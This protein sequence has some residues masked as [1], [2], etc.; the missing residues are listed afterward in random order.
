M[1]KWMPTKQVRKAG[2]FLL[3]LFMCFSMCS[4]GDNKKEKITTPEVLDDFNKSD[5]TIGVV[6]GYIFDK[7]VA[8]A[9]PD[10][11]I[12][13]FSSRDNA[14]RALVSG[15]VDGVADDEPIIRSIMRSTDELSL[16]DGYLEPAQ[17]AFVF[18][19]D[20]KGKKLSYEFSE[21]VIKL[22]ED[23]ELDDLEKKWFGN[24]T[25]DK[26]SD[27][28]DNLPAKNGTL[29]LAFDDSNIPFAYMSAGKP[30]GYDIDLAIGFCREYGYGLMINKVDF[31]SVLEKTADGVYDIGCGAITIT[32]ER[33]DNLYFGEADYEGGVCIC[34][35]NTVNDKNNDAGMISG[36]KRSFKRVFI[37]DSRYKLF[38]KGILIT[39]IITFFSAVVGAPFG[40][41]LYISSRRSGFINRGLSK[42]VI[43]ILHGIPAVM[44]MSILYYTYYEDMRRGGI[45]AAIIGFGLTFSIDIYMIIKRYA[46]KIDDGNLERDYRLYAIDSGDFFRKLF[47]VYGND[48]RYD[49]TDKLTTLLKMTSVVGYIAVYD[50]TKIFEVIKKESLE[51][52]LPLLATTVVYFIIIK[53]ISLI[54]HKNVNIDKNINE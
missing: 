33:K 39:L 22:R 13:Y 50:M 1:L 52:T 41:L 36:M 19:K 26:Q 16:I 8:D 25:D 28:Y 34:V 7:S 11:D 15:V 12:K 5:I 38:I 51:T 9:L 24:Q 23:G 29:K 40:Y 2:L 44:L 49:F 42:F 18:T 46:A 37:N 3:V 21:Y 35:S 6:S 10:A 14:Y 53:L 17:Y 20:E 54:F 45:L 31:S 4:C 47:D 48:I 43:W 27:D 30:V 32:E